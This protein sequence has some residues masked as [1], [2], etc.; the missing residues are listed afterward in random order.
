MKLQDAI[1]CQILFINAIKDAS[2]INKQKHPIK[3][4]FFI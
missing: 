2:I 3:L 1:I 4:F